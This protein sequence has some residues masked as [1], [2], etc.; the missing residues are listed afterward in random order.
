M[1]KMQL[2]NFKLTLRIS[3]WRI[4]MYICNIE[5]MLTYAFTITCMHS[6][7]KLREVFFVYAHFQLRIMARNVRCLCSVG[8]GSFYQ[9]FSP[10]FLFLGLQRFVGKSS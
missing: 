2:D 10:A 8:L 5:N 3:N 7:W 6:S 4:Y 1:A 9:L